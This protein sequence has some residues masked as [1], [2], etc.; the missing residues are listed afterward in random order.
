M[1]AHLK[2]EDELLTRLATK[3]EKADVALERQN[4]QMRGLLK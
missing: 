3:T 4:E 1:N 2:D